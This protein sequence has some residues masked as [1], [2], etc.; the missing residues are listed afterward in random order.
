MCDPRFARPLVLLT[1]PL[2]AAPAF[3]ATCESLAKLALPATTIASAQSVAAGPF[4]LAQ[5]PPVAAP[6][7]C[8]AD[9]SSLERKRQGR[10][11]DHPSRTAAAMDS[12]AARTEG[13][14]PPATPITSAKAIPEPMIAGV[15]RN[16]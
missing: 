2:L 16:A 5:G 6:A 4:M 11:R 7:F 8:R 13:S 9:T 3:G 1:L 14:S 12:R 10:G 15:M